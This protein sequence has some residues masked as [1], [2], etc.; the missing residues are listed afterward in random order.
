VYLTADSPNELVQLDS[1]KIYI[2]G[3]IVDRNRHKGICYKRAQEAGIA[4]AKLPISQH[5]KLQT[6]VVRGWL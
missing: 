1:S 5:V 4:T 2:I 3:G 6:S